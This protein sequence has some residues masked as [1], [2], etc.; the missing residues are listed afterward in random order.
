MSKTTFRRV[1][2][3]VPNDDEND[4]YDDGNVDN[5]DDE[6]D[7]KPDE[8]HDLMVKLYLSKALSL[9]KKKD[10]INWAAWASTVRIHTENPNNFY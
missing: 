1:Q 10:Q 3:Q 5:F 8:Y 9:G 6:I 7:Q 4:H 2:N